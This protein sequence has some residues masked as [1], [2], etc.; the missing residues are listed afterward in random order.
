M[1][2]KLGEGLIPV[3]FIHISDAVIGS[4]KTRKVYYPSPEQIPII[5]ER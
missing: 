2:H 4:G 5:V 1:F 3:L